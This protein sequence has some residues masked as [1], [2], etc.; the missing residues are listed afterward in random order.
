MYPVIQ[1]FYIQAF[2]HFTDLDQLNTH[3]NLLVC[4]MHKFITFEHCLT[5]YSGILSQLPPIPGLLSG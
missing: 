5:A 1:Q 4:S 3:V 2:T